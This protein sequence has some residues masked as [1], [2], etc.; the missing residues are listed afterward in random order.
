MIFNHLK[1]KF[2]SLAYGPLRWLVAVVATVQQTIKY[3]SPVIIYIDKDGDWNNKR[4]G[5]HLVSP[6]LNVATMSQIKAAAIDYW[7]YTYVPKVGDIVVD[8]GA[9]IGDDAIIFSEMVKESGSVYAIEAH[10]V[11]FRCLQKTIKLNKLNNVIAINLAISDKCGFLG[12]SSGDSYLSNSIL[13]TNEASSVMV[14][15]DTL[16]SVFDKFNIYNI[17]FLK[18]NI[19]GGELP[20]MDCSQNGMGI[21]KNLAIACHDFKA[22]DEVSDFRTFIKIKSI[23]ERDGYSVINRPGDIRPYILYTLYGTRG[24]S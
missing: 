9:G 8:V 18:M 4:I 21:P 11:T 17:D 14:P 13:M 12:I 1:K 7:C 10:P 2:K 6:E 5:L 20:A 15:A 24:S 19:E 23:L 16:G 3:L 22:N